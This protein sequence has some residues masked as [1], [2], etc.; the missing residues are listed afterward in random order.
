LRIRIGGDAGFR[1]HV[2]AG[3]LSHRLLAD[4]TGI[5]EI[6]TGL[7]EVRGRGLERLL[8]EVDGAAHALGGV[9]RER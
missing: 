7:L 2:A 5:L 6:A 4:L 8:P 9:R 3:A 1:G